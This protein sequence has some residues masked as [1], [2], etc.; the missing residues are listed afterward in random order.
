MNQAPIEHELPF[1]EDF[2]FPESDDGFGALLQEVLLDMRPLGPMYLAI[3]PVTEPTI[4]IKDDGYFRHYNISLILENEDWHRYADYF[5]NIR[6]NHVGRCSTLKMLGPTFVLGETLCVNYTF[7]SSYFETDLMV[8]HY[9]RIVSLLRELFYDEFAVYAFRSNPV[10]YLEKLALYCAK[11]KHVGISIVKTEKF[12]SLEV[13][14]ACSEFEVNVLNGFTVEVSA[15]YVKAGIPETELF[16]IYTKLVDVLPNSSNKGMY[17][18]W[19]KIDRGQGKVS[20]KIV[21]LP[22][23]I[24]DL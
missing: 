13:P 2:V 17:R 4:R 22:K 8:K 18:H 3:T 10:C 24:N 12:D 1:D 14:C 9:E 23:V 15:D 19:Y 5:Y 11:S 16:T 20:F 21:S 6:N 7:S